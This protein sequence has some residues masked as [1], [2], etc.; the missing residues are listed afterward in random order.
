MVGNL[1]VS[2]V[3]DMKTGNSVGPPVCLF[4]CQMSYG[5]PIAKHNCSL[6]VY[7]DTVNTIA[8]VGN[9]CP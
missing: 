4:N 3:Q 9:A 5:S 6:F 7:I 8:D 1:W 2:Q